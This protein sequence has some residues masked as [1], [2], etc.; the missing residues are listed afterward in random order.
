MLGFEIKKKKKDKE[1]SK[2]RMMK[3]IITVCISFI[4]LYTVCEW[5]RV[6]KFGGDTST[7]TNC[8]FAFFGTELVCGALMKYSENKNGG[9]KNG[10][11]GK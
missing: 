10:M 5:Y 9:N 2:P 1:K 7:L 8:V 3:V 4:T 11:D 6:W